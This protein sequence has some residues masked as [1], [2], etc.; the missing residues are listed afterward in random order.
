MNKSLFKDDYQRGY[1]ETMESVTQP[2][3]SMSLR[4]I[5]DK[6]AFGQELAIGRTDGIFDPDDVDDFVDDETQADGFDFAMA[7]ELLNDITRSQEAAEQAALSASVEPQDGEADPAA[8]PEQGAAS[9]AA[10]E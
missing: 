3:M 5:I 10:H 1:V 9:S 8:S 2:D 4:E 6:F 7:H